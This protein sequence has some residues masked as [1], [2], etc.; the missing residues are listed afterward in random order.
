MDV[1]HGPSGGLNPSVR[2]G[3]SRNAFQIRPAV[4]EESP[5]LPAIDARDQWVASAGVSS[6][7]AT[8][9]ASTCSPVIVSGRP[10]RSS[11]DNPPSPAAMNRD[12]HFPAVAAWQ[13]SA[14][15]TSL[16]SLPSAQAST[17]FARSA[18]AC[19]DLARRACRSSVARS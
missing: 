15:A 11:S 8:I 10:D 18:S 1:R 9:T 16:L 14:A 2:C 12:R 19:A 5:G 3:L 17:I 6:R 7:V 4:E 13:P